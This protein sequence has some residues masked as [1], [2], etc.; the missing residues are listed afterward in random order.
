[1]TFKRAPYL[2]DAV[3]RLC[4]QAKCWALSRYGD[5]LGSDLPSRCQEWIEI[6]AAVIV[7]EPGYALRERVDR[8]LRASAGLFNYPKRLI[9]T[10]VLPKNLSGALLNCDCGC[11]MPRRVPERAR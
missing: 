11:A 1:L 2:Y 6:V 9:L 5:V 3:L 8:C 10:D 7:A 4:E